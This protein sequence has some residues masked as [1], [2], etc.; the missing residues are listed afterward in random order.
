MVVAFLSFKSL[1]VAKRPRRVAVVFMI[2]VL[3]MI[4]SLLNNAIPQIE[5][6]ASLQQS[7]NDTY[8][9]IG[10]RFKPTRWFI[11]DLL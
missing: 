1:G 9:E 6:T 10:G 8:A 7:P 4:Y 5:P 2:Y 3:F 11:W